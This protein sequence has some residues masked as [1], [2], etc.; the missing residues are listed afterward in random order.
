MP[1]F[2][3]FQGLPIVACAPCPGMLVGSCGKTSCGD[4]L[5]SMLNVDHCEQQKYYRRWRNLLGV[6]GLVFSHK[7]G[8]SNLCRKISSGCCA[9]VQKVDGTAGSLLVLLGCLASL[10]KR[11]HCSCVSNTAGSA[12]LLKT[13]FRNCGILFHVLY[14]VFYPCST[15]H[16]PRARSQPRPSS[17]AR[18]S[19]TSRRIKSETD[20]P[21]S[22]ARFTS[23]AICGLVKT[24]DRCW[25]FIKWMNTPLIPSVKRAV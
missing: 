9:G 19:S 1:F 7:I 13:P 12:F 23:H 4:I 22:L 14:K 20:M 24:I 18:H 10:C 3:V 25:F 17:L 16:T 6:L 15:P 8:D 11:P 5:S 21:S 2:C